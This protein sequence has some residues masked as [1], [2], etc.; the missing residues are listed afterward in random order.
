MGETHKKMCRK[1]VKPC[2]WM[3]SPKAEVSWASR[4]GSFQRDIRKP[5][6]HI[7]LAPAITLAQCQGWVPAVDIFLDPTETLRWQNPECS[8][9]PTYSEL[10][11]LTPVTWN[12]SI[13]TAC[14]LSLSTS[15]WILPILLPTSWKLALVS[16]P[17]STPRHDF[18]LIQSHP[19]SKFWKEKEVEPQ[20]LKG[21]HHSL[22]P[23]ITSTSSIKPGTPGPQTGGH[24]SLFLLFTYKSSWE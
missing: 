8:W 3:S 21:I 12:K 7:P 18:L 19:D 6:R 4:R 1:C 5:H 13:A 23:A 11:V 16:Q 24:H 2:T 17:G 14:Y 22:T 9:G 15:V 20:L 10:P